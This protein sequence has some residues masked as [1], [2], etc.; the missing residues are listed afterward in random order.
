MPTG[1]RYFLDTNIVIALFSHDPK[2]VARLETT[3]E[4]F[5]SFVVLGELHF[6]AAN[7]S[8]RQE[9]TAQVEDFAASC[10]LV[11]VDEP[12]ARCFGEMKAELRR[13]GRPIPEND[14][15]LAASATAHGLTLVTR[16]AH[17]GEVDVLAIET[18]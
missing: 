11:P 12:A 13:K 14:L 10:T 1:G 2:V 4:V 16:D 3:P 7:S 15:W 8:R 6:G 5:L 18:W 9:N 17:F